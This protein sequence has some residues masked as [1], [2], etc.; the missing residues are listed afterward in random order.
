MSCRSWR[1]FS[2][3]HEHVLMTIR[4]L[5]LQPTAVASVLSVLARTRCRVVAPSKMLPNAASRSGSPPL[6]T[7]SSSDCAPAV[8]SLSISCSSPIRLSTF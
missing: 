6:S 7:P 2:D 4:F 5:D 3:E 1:L 8:L